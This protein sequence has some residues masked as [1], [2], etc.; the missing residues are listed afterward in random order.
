MLT[1]YLTP[2]LTSIDVHKNEIG[3]RAGKIMMQRIAHPE[4]PQQ[5]SVVPAELYEG[6]SVRRIGSTDDADE[7]KA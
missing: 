4:L 2:V 7:E 5:T 1:E 6:A 3:K